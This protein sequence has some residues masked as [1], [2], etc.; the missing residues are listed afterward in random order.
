MCSSCKLRAGMPY[1]NRG[2]ASR[3][4]QR[5]RHPLLWVQRAPTCLAGREIKHFAPTNLCCTMSR[6]TLEA[7]KPTAA[8]RRQG[9]GSCWHKHHGQVVLAHEV[10]PALL[11]LDAGGS[12]LL[13]R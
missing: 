11:H 3:L 1:P 7:G 8:A 6:N 5:P 13:P 12:Q 4:Q 2:A 9:N 10:P